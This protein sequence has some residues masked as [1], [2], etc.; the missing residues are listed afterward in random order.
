MSCLTTTGAWLM[1]NMDDIII[2]NCTTTQC[3]RYSLSNQLLDLKT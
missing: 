1:S 3:D 2:K